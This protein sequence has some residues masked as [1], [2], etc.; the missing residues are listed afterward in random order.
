MKKDSSGQMY[1]QCEMMMLISIKKEENN[2][3]SNNKNDHIRTII[4]IISKNILQKPLGPHSDPDSYTNSLSINLPFLF[5]QHWEHM[6][7]IDYARVM[8]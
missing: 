1:L 3:I 6:E 5:F 7:N 8:Y 4:M 2:I